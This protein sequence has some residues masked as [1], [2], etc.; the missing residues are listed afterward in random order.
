MDNYRIIWNEEMVRRFYSGVDRG[1]LYIP[2]VA[3][4]P[5]NGI[6]EVV[7]SSPD[8]VMTQIFQDGQK[9]KVRR[10]ELNY[11]CSLKVY[12]YPEEFEPYSGY[13]PSLLRPFSFSY[14]VMTG[15]TS[16]QIHL[17]Y[18]VVAIPDDVVFSSLSDSIDPTVFSWKFSTRPIKLSGRAS[19]SHLIL[20]SEII[21]PWTLSAIE[22]QLYGAEGIIPHMPTPSEIEQIFE[23]NAILKVVDLG[24]GTFSVEGPD[25]AIQNL[26]SDI[27]QI[28]WPSL[29]RLSEYEYQISSL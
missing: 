18:N 4:I 19:S 7:G 21:H 16:Y 3:G 12:T 5:W 13:N 6:L 27:I 24:D 9:L 14:R 25:Q 8:S 20:D 11:E 23:D 28:E 15:E 2:E 29:I 22:D 26:G 1:M 10:R 17:V